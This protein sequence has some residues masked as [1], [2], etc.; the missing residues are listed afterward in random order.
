MIDTGH[1]FLFVTWIMSIGTLQLEL[2]IL[3]VALDL[4]VFSNSYTYRYISLSSSLVQRSRIAEPSYS[5]L[6]FLSKAPPKGE[7]E[8]EGEE[9]GLT[10][11]GSTEYYRGF[12]TSDLHDPSINTIQRGDGLDQAIKLGSY[13]AVFLGVLVAAF[14]ASNGVL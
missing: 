5:S 8:T 6:L 9:E 13:T 2:L 7:D 10:K 11:V 12:F 14:L 1:I 3:V 4:L